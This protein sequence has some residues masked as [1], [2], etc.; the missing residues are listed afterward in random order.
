MEEIKKLTPEQLAELRAKIR[1]ANPDR[2]D[3]D[4]ATAV[5]QPQENE[6]V[7]SPH[8]SKKKITVEI[9][10]D[11]M[12]ATIMLA[13]PEDEKY[14]VPELVGELRQNKVVVG[15]KTE[16]LIKM[17]QEKIYDTPVEVAAGKPL[18]PAQEGYFEF[19]FDTEEHKT[20][21]IKEDGTTD[22]AA[23]GRLENVKEGQLIARYHPAVQG[24]NGYD[25]MGHEMVAKIARELNVLRGQHIER[26]D[27]TNEYFATLSGKISLKDNNIEILDVYE[28]NEDVTII[29]QKVE[30]YGDLT[31]NGDVEN[32]VTIRAGRN[33]VINGTVGA[34]FIY[35]GGDIILKRGITGAG[36]GKVSARGNI[37]SDFIEHA[38]VEAGQDVYANSII[39]SEVIT[40]GN[41]TVSGKQGSIIGGNT[42][43]L[44]GIVANA[45][46]SPSEVKTILHAGFLKEDYTK[47]L[48]LDTKEK[49]TAAQLEQLVDE[50]TTLLKA[51]AKAGSI[52]DSQR[53]RIMNMNK[54]KDSLQEELRNI[55]SDKE[56]LS[57]KMAMGGNAS[58]IIRGDVH[59]NVLISIDT[60]K[61][62]ILAK[63]TYIR[64]VC[65]N[66]AIER[67]TVPLTYAQI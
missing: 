40:N 9:A 15:I 5:E 24:T 46:G 26:N 44:K 17:V 30:F 48:V 21:V 47:F 3:S 25:V 4:A 2:K 28:I 22:Y 49:K 58:I 16:A 62:S 56:D 59:R 14:L 65:R 37:F 64:Y 52:T 31:I 57:R 11:K 53:E 32:G 55:K 19:F 34:A 29:R 43:G 51:R 33:V 61:L 42:H 10:E 38:R 12:S 67:R 41:V 18:V 63:E 54:T 13:D 23:V 7:W 6:A 20:P 66:D 39:N 50:M 60:A 8:I 1:N 45:A 27:E 35:A 36:R